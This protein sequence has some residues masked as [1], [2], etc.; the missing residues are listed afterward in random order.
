MKHEN[1][2]LVRGK[3]ICIRLSVKRFEL[4]HEL[5]LVFTENLLG[6]RRLSKKKKIYIYEINRTLINL[7]VCETNNYNFFLNLLV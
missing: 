3:L 4:K 1:I 5:F 6:S 7:S 2:R